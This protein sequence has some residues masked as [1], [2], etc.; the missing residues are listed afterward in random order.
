MKITVFYNHIEE[1]MAATGR[2]LKEIATDLKNVGITGVEMDYRDLCKDFS[3]AGKLY[4]EGLSINSC[5]MFFDWGKKPFFDPVKAKCL[6]DLKALH[7][8]NLLVVPGFITDEKKFKK[9]RKRMLR[10][11]KNLSFLAKSMGIKLFME[12][13]DDET[14][15]IKSIEGLKWFLDRAPYVKCA[16]DTGNFMPH[17][18]DELAAYKVFKDNIGYVHLKDRSL[19]KK[20]GETPKMS[21]EGKALYSSAVG[22]GDVKMKEICEA[23]K[24]KA[25]DK[26]VAIEH[27]GSKTMYEDMISSA[28]WI[29]KN[30]L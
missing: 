18:E 5:Y 23:L 28:K 22:S 26:T 30:L 29:R 27:F 19:N 17:G 1:A 8:E 10:Q 14:S 4:E 15:P 25:Y 9:E 13:F 7:V 6:V 24:K 16:F 3:I 11:L 2:S 20:E 21:I 12:D